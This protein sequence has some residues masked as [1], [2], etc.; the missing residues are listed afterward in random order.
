MNEAIWLRKRWERT[1]KNKQWRPL[2]DTAWS[3]NAGCYTPSNLITI[4]IKWPQSYLIRHQYRFVVAPLSPSTILFSRLMYS[5]GHLIPVIYISLMAHQPHLNRLKIRSS[6]G[7]TTVIMK[8]WLRLWQSCLYSVIRLCLVQVASICEI[9]RTSAQVEHWELV[10]FGICLS[11]LPSTLLYVFRVSSP[12]LPYFIISLSCYSL[13]NSSLISV[14]VILH[15]GLPSIS[16]F[17]LSLQ[18]NS[19][20]IA[21]LMVVHVN[22]WDE[23]T[24]SN[25]HHISWLLLRVL[26]IFSSSNRNT[27]VRHPYFSPVPRFSRLVA[28]LYYRRNDTRYHLSVE[29]RKKYSYL[30]SSCWGTLLPTERSQSRSLLMMFLAWL[31]M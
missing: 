1:R 13:S 11:L 4:V 20:R 23:S 31:W 16:Y 26:N 14:F 28:L 17:S 25:L 30:P 15:H 9:M 19:H 10:R 6:L 7:K 3:D 2:I 29:R 8:R 22:K 18:G 27:N 21:M 12:I 5:H 24:F